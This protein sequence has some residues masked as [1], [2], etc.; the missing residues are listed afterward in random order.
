MPEVQR[1]TRAESPDDLRLARIYVRVGLGG[2]DDDNSRR[3]LLRG[4]K[5]AAGRL[6]ARMGQ[7]LALRYTPEL[8]FHYDEGPDAVARVE[9]LLAEIRSEE[10]EHDL[11]PASSDEGAGDEGGAADEAGAV[12]E[13]NDSSAD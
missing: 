3:D 4:L 8:R 9:E 2:S 7:R 1:H 11:Q 6:R 5:R 13:A 10:P 12:D